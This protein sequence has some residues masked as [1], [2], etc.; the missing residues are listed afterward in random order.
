MGALKAAR[1]ARGHKMGGD[2]LY[3]RQNGQREC[4]ACSAIR[5]AAWRRMKKQKPADTNRRAVMDKTIRVYSSLAAMKTDE[6]LEWQ[7]MEPYE[8][9]NAA[10]ELSLGAYGAKESARHVSRGVPGTL[11]RIERSQG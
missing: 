9:L 11:V 7:Q 8:R 6:Y 3:V 2:N 5:V 1:C 10:A 4:R